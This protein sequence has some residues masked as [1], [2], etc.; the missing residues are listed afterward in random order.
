M[1]QVFLSTFFKTLDKKKRISVPASFRSVLEAQGSMGVVG[2]RSLTLPAIDCFSMARMET[3][4]QRLDSLDLFSDEQNN[5]ALSIFA[6]AQ[7]LTFDKDGRITLPDLW[8]THGGID[9]EVAFV[10]RG[11]TFQ[12]WSPHNFTS[13]QTDARAALKTSK[14]TLKMTS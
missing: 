1:A 8:K 10:G 3:L 5:V 12:I 13:H 11:H 6:D 4:G 7:H 14:F 9:T 2:F